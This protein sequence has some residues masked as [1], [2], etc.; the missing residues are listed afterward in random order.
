MQLAVLP[1]SSTELVTACL[2]VG[3]GV[4]QEPASSAGVAAATQT[5]VVSA[6]SARGPRDPAVQ[7]P[8][9]TLEQDAALYCFSGPPSAWKAVA[10]AALEPLRLRL[11]AEQVRA[12]VKP[13]AP[14]PA[15]ALDALRAL[16]FAGQSV[17]ERSVAG[18]VEPAAGPAT[19]LEFANQQMVASNAVLVLQSPE[20]CQASMSFVEGLAPEVPGARVGQARLAVIPER[21]GRHSS[22]RFTAF[23]A[24]S[25]SGEQVAMGWVVPGPGSERYRA[26]KLAVELLAG[27]SGSR[28]SVMLPQQGL[29]RARVTSGLDEAKGPALLWVLLD[30]GKQAKPERLEALALSQL[31]SLAVA[32]P[33][34]RELRAARERLTWGKAP[35]P[36]QIALAMLRYGGLAAVRREAAALAGVTVRDV[37]EAVAA[38]LPRWQRSVAEARGPNEPL[39]PVGSAYHVVRAGETL[40]AVALRYGV[41]PGALAQLN[42]LTAGDALVGGR[43]LLLPAAP[44]GTPPKASSPASH[45][46]PE[47]PAPVHAATAPA[48]APTKPVGKPVKLQTHVVAAGDTLQ[49]IARKYGVELADLIHANALR[50]NHP[51]FPG[52]R[53]V[54]PKA[55]EP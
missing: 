50:G 39:P 37:K 47:R 8:W 7:G 29:G 23:E 52:Q 28:L 20:E 21:L 14:S 31:E 17:L 34:D 45:G 33:T 3:A 2:A 46:K 1:A 32:G 43:V 44:K 12:P 30:A 19:V 49:N 53:L 4:R 15:P 9:A 11:T 22:E 40:G 38:E 42:G 13:R 6:L 35:T 24:P 41:Q 36:E 26:L 10:R 5:A 48:A 25:G 55:A 16:A 18:S 27:A 51:I 54:I